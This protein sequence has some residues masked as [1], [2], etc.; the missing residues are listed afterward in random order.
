MTYTVFEYQGHGD[1]E[2]DDLAPGRGGYKY[3]LVNEPPEEAV[4]WWEDTFGQDPTEWR[5]GEYPETDGGEAW[6]VSEALT[7]EQARAH[8]GELEL[9]AGGIGVPMKRKY[10]WD[11]L[12]GRLDVWVVQSAE[13]VPDEM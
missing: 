7:E 6:D 3:V 5:P 9:E 1:N 4:L 13:D 10:T 11:E 2:T 8:C 12:R